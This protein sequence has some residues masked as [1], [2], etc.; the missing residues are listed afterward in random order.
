MHK[1]VFSSSGNRLLWKICY[2]DRQFQGSRKRN[3][4]AVF[5]LLRS[6]AWKKSWNELDCWAFTTGIPGTYVWWLQAYVWWLKNDWLI[7]IV[8]QNVLKDKL[9]LSLFLKYCCFYLWLF[10]KFP[11][12]QKLIYWNFDPDDLSRKISF[13]KFS[14]W[15]N[16]CFKQQ[17]CLFWMTFSLPR[18]LHSS[19]FIL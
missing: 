19:R 8:I 16:S 5:I 12:E 2:T 10:L 9:S 6:S 14:S 3:M 18:R 7:A 13:E 15:N 11:R 4:V 17:R 1:Q